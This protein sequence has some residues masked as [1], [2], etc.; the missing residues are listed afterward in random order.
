MPALTVLIPLL[1]PAALL[2]M[3]LALGRFEEAVLA[4]P[5]RDD[6]TAE[7]TA[8]ADGESASAVGGPELE[9]SAVTS[10]E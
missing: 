2:G 7:P 8:E 10:T 4:P 6:D 9:G 1:L 3:V 5:T